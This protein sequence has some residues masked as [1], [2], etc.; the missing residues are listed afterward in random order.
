[1]SKS[2]IV[3]CFILFA[4]SL[5]LSE[6]QIKFQESDSELNHRNERKFRR[7]SE[8]GTR[9]PRRTASLLDRDLDDYDDR[10]KELDNDDDEDSDNGDGSRFSYRRTSHR[11]KNEKRVESIEK[12]KSSSA[13]RSAS[14]R[15]NKNS[16]LVARYTSRNERNLNRKSQLQNI[17]KPTLL[18]SDPF[19][20]F[21]AIGTGFGQSSGG[22]A[23][24]A[25]FSRS[26]ERNSF[27]G[28]YGSSNSR[29][30]EDK[31]ADLIEREDIRQANRKR[32]LRRLQN[33]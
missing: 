1:M 23:F 17:E 29:D 20:L 32:E 13:S 24:G 15:R 25:G 8:F 10:S 5:V 31:L 9:Q 19:E 2:L 7:V 6:R 4:S 16:D 28:G 3:I 12:T 33:H 14:N 30:E 21:E 26:T 11:L 18:I 27:G 22:R